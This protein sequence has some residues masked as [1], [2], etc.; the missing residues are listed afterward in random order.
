[1]LK[2]CETCKKEFVAAKRTRRF[3]CWPCAAKAR[4]VNRQCLY[5]GMS[6]K[7]PKFCN[8]S[9]AALYNNDKRIY[10][11][12]KRTDNYVCVKCGKQIVK[13]VRSDPKRVVCDKCS[14]KNKIYTYKRT[15]IICGNDFIGNWKQKTC[16]RDCYCLH[17]S[18]LRQKYL[19]TH[20]SFSTKRTTF[21]YKHVTVETDSMLEQAAVMYL[22]DYKHIDSIERFRSLVCYKEGTKTRTFNPDFWCRKGNKRFVAE[23]KMKWSKTS[24]HKY[25]RTIPQKKKALVEFCSVKGYTPFWIDFE[26]TPELRSIYEK[27]KLASRE[28]S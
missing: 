2:I 5:C 26:T 3:C 24:T 17:F 14:Y 28:I 19:Q 15:C 21:T 11:K 20:G 4:I 1:M 10:T 7:N 23:V 27:V 8:H 25:N 16:S 18:R 22:V 13:S 12:D 6:T 9:C